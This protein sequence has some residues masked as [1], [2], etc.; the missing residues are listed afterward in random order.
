MPNCFQLTRKSD[1]QSG[2]VSLVKIDSELCGLL[3][4]E[5]HPVKYVR[6]WFDFIGF[7]LATGSTFAD[8]R[9]RIAEISGE[10]PR[11]EDSAEYTAARLKYWR[12]MRVCCD[13]LDE[14]FTPDNWVEI[15]GFASR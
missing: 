8:I 11:P 9:Q 14:N 12:E 7:G 10:Q 13:Y 3:G 5:I 1:L 4:V 2:P 6:G 15:G